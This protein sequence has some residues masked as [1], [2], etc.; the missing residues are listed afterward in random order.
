MEIN[1]VVPGR[2][3]VPQPS[4]RHR[5]A[6]DNLIDKLQEI[7]ASLEMLDAERSLEEIEH[8]LRPD[9]DCE[10]C[11]EFENLRETLNGDRTVGV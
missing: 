7:E 11:R 9:C 2:T 5:Q 8:D 4:P 10:G 3:G 1:T 6:M